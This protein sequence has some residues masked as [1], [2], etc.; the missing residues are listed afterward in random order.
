MTVQHLIQS[1]DS[2]VDQLRI[3]QGNVDPIC[4]A[5]DDL[6]SHHTVC[7]ETGA[8]IIEQTAFLVTYRRYLQSHL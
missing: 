3:F 2:I 5:A 7:E 6:F 4:S 1:T 8:K